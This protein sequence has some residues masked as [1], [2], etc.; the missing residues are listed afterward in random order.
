MEV[1]GWNS[2]RSAVAVKGYL[3]FLAR[4]LVTIPRHPPRC[5]KAQTIYP[6]KAKQNFCGHIPAPS[7]SQMPLSQNQLKI[8]ENNPDKIH[9]RVSAPL[10]RVENQFLMVARLWFF[11]LDFSLPSVLAADFRGLQ[12]DRLGVCNSYWASDPI[13]GKHDWNAGVESGSL[14]WV[15]FLAAAAAPAGL[16]SVRGG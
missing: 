14:W 16:R 6:N 7:F 1:S 3:V 8:L 2:R 15:V 11:F 12:D 4:D 10:S 13:S 9:S 5:Q